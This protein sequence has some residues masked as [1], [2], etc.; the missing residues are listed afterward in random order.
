MLHSLGTRRRRIEGIE[1]RDL[2][3]P[4]LLFRAL[5]RCFPGPRPR[6]RRRREGQERRLANSQR[7]SLGGLRVAVLELERSTGEEIRYAG[8]ADDDGAISVR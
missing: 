5:Q 2:P 1:E 3:A 7:L 8:L 4:L 6:H